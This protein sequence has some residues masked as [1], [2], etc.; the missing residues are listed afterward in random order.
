M[1]EGVEGRV[2]RFREARARWD[3]RRAGLVDLIEELPAAE[4]V[5][6][7]G[8]LGWGK[9]VRITDGVRAALREAI[10]AEVRDIDEELVAAS[11]ALGAA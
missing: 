4:V 9:D 1:S 2:E 8:V 5:R 7:G 6:V 10:E 3:Y 11:E